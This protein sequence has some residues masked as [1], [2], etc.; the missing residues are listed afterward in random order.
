MLG[1]NKPYTTGSTV[2]GT[3]IVT[4]N[5]SYRNTGT[6]VRVTPLV[7]ADK[8]VTLDLHYEESRMVYPEGG[9]PVG[10]GKDEKGNPIL[11]PEF[12]LTTLTSK[13][14]VASGKAL[15]VDG[16]KSTA[17]SG[18]GSVLIVVGARVVESK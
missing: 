3:G 10:N 16:D 8:T 6:Q 14:S 15:L 5:I 13:V 18:S 2:T 1:E 12:P 7:A 9:I 17:K 11:A 4:R